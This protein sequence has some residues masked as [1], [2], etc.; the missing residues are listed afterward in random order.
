MTKTAAKSKPEVYCPYCGAE[1]FLVDDT[2][3]YQKSYGGKVW[4]CSP[5][6]AWVGCHK[7]SKNHIPLGRLANASLRKLKIRAHA[8]FDPLWKAAKQHRGWTQS[9]ARAKAYSWLAKSMDIPC[10]ECH[11]GMFDE[12]RVLLAIEVLRK[13]EPAPSTSNDS[14]K[15]IH[16]QAVKEA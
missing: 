15:E 8:L 1:A 14:E 3:V 9:H 16:G 13:R 4:L 12:D 6:K 2:A 5:C 10:S 11:I 7:N